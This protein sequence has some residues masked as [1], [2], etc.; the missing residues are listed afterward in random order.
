MWFTS[1]LI[2]CTEGKGMVGLKPGLFCTLAPEM[3]Y[4]GGF[5]GEFSFRFILTNFAV[6][7]MG[8]R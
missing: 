1:D 7:R 8:N 3:V 6:L 2:T 4:P 5:A